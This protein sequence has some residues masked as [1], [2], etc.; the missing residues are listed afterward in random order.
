MSFG[1]LALFGIALYRMSFKLI[2]IKKKSSKPNHALSSSRTGFMPN[3]G[4]WGLPGARGA[5]GAE[6]RG[7]MAIPPVSV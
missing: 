7:E 1:R 6:G 2:E 4:L 3:I 5:P